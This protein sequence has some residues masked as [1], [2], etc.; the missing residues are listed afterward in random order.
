MRRFVEVAAVVIVAIGGV[1]CN[2]AGRAKQF[3]AKGNLLFDQQKYDEASI[4]YR[5]ALQADPNMGETYYRLGL[6]E[7]KLN[8]RSESAA[9]LARAAALMPDHEDANAR[10]GE[11][12][13]MSYQADHQQAAYEMARKIA[14][15]LLVRRPDS[16]AGLR[17]KGYLALVDGKPVEVVQFLTRANAVR[18]LAP[19]VVTTLVQN[20]LL[21]GRVEQAEA[22]AKRLISAHPDCGAI[23][24]TLYGYYLRNGRDADAEQILIAK[25]QKNPADSLP[26][27][28]LAEHYW[29]HQAQAQ[30]VKT[31]SSLLG[32]RARFPQAYWT[33]AEFYQQMGDWA[34]EVHTL[35]TGT[36]AEPGK[37]LAYQKKAVEALLLA[38]KKHDAL[39]RVAVL[40]R[41]FPA[42]NDV[43]GAW[44]TLLLDSAQPPERQFALRELQTL[45]Q[46]A[47]GNVAFQYQLAR[48]YVMDGQ[49]AQAR[50]QFEKVV[51]QH[52]SYS[53]AWLALAELAS[54][55]LD[56]TACQRY[57]DR[58]L[59]LD[60][61]LRSASLLKASA[62]VGLHR[63]EEA[64]AAYDQLIRRY[65][66]YREAQLQ[67]GLLDVVQGQYRDAEKIFRANYRP[68][69]SD[70]RSLA[71]L[72]EMYFS[73]GRP[74]QAFELLN[75]ETRRFP[76]AI[77]LRA[78]TAAAAMRAGKWDV[79]IGEY[80]AMR[81]RN[82]DDPGI[83]LALGDAYRRR[84][85]LQRAGAALE[86]AQ[87]IRP[88]DWRTP[89]LLGYIYQAQGQVQRAEASYQ[90]C[91]RLNPEY[92][93]ALNNLAFLIAQND[94][95]LDEAL[96][97]ANQAVR[98]SGGSAEATD[99]LGW[100]YL[101]KRNL[102]AARQIFAALVR[103][104]PDNS[105]LHY[106]FGLTLHQKGEEAQ[107]QQELRAAIKAG[108]PPTERSAANALVLPN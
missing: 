66:D 94:R 50:Q 21:D 77:E 92:P 97:L 16:F 40:A 104:R 107:A 95:R 82:P 17:L 80:E 22:L 27:K 5:K 3:L 79:A 71:G 76:T 106:H 13:L 42:D 73:Q 28:Q 75:G 69:S 43:R 11:L 51:H 1:A 39:A 23:Y 67:R 6:T 38:G 49:Y 53:P 29:R 103:K 36:A 37:K 91:L 44:A 96:A 102:D 48:A 83:L 20:L 2:Q 54:K 56:F 34:E 74:D 100:I 31:I 47:P 15:R 65:P 7:A 25:I 18:P 4:N 12:Y 89:F 46:N 60:P 14:D 10:L 63:F 88:A 55:S 84:G 93:E 45:A 58:A 70:F 68:G 90:Q 108:L 30:A 86:H 61:S 9:A 8:H 72:I 105:I 19:D 32:D 87:A 59:S 99:T 85:D 41:A 78:M 64:G 33:V 62:L 26:V 101:R 81:S 52:R 24:D 98:A 35:D 57:A